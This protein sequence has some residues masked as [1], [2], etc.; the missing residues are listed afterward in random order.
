MRKPEDENRLIIAD[1]GPEYMVCSKCNTVMRSGWLECFECGVLFVY[2]EEPG[3]HELENKRRYG[4]KWIA[5]VLKMQEEARM[6][7][8]AEKEKDQDLKE[9][10]LRK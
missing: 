3:A 10:L 4:F 1:Y 6:K 9:G 2:D 7:N 5:D 8:A